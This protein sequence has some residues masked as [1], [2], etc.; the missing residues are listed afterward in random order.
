MLKRAAILAALVASFATAVSA[1][2]D[3]RSLQIIVS[4]D[5][6][7]LSVYD[8]GKVVATSKVSTGKHGHDTP[9]GI[10]SVLEKRKFHKSN[11]YSDAP[12]PYMQRLTWSGIA[13]H[14]SNSVPN[15]PASHGC[16]RLPAAFA[17]SLYQMTGRGVHVII[18]DA[19]VA[20]VAID[21]PLMFSP[22]AQRPAGDLLSDVPLRPSSA[23]SSIEQIEVAMNM[24]RAPLNILSDRAA[25][26]ADEPEPLR[27]L[28]TRR[29]DRE[30]IADVQTMLTG[31]GFD[32]GTPD[33]VAGSTTRSAVEA[34]KR[35]KNL[36]AR[37]GVLSDAFLKAIYASA[38]RP[39]PP[40]G[41]LMVRQ[42]FA[43]L[44]SEPVDIA[45]PQI[46]LGTHFYSLTA[47]DRGRGKASWQG[48][49]LA[50]AIPAATAKRLGITSDGTAGE[51]SLKGVLD[52]ISMSDDLR[53]R[54][55]AMISTGSSLT[56][57][58]AGTESETGKGTDFITITHSG[59][60]G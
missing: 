4:K 37:S 42:G 56:I 29:T 20:P 35:W 54:I 28:I 31:L 26:S 46:A 3:P 59:A 10:F 48:L 33:G 36:P 47:I 14:E 23:H 50:N 11:I 8:G 27:V 43:P 41:Q 38:D 58:D 21:H 32:A 9:T 13:L 49:T 57:T 52:R 15:Y 40:K 39:A 24:P 5:S 44:I 7:S 12:M 51:S 53:R 34:F 18:S 17:K 19:A 55:S 1:G 16:V 6:Q 60:K 30:V 2:D 25:T 22:P 45:R